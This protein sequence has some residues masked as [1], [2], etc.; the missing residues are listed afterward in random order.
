MTNKRPLSLFDIAWNIWCVASVIGIWPRH[1]EPRLITTTRVPIK[2]PNLHPSLHGLRVVQFS[3]L[4]FHHA[5]SDRFIK[6]LISKIQKLKP[7]VIAFTGDFIC[8]SHLDNP[9]KLQSIFQALKAPFGCYA[10]L[11]NHDYQN[12]VSITSEGHYDVLDSSSINMRRGWRRLFYTPTLSKIVSEKAQKVPMKQELVDMLRATP[13]QLLHNE[14][15]LVP[16]R[17]TFLNICGLGEYVLGRC[18]PKTTFQDYDRSYPG[19]VLAH[20]PDSVPRLQPFPGDLILCG[21]THGGQINIPG[22]WKKFT[23]MENFHLKSGL[24]RIEDKWVYINR[25]VGAVMPFRWFSPPEIT[26]FTLECL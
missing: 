26:L 20:N 1:I 12:Y 4:H 18:D 14:S 23:L 22:M 9:Q 15:L 10:V 6:K 7:D 5:L 21:H 8:A 19:I 16:I 25:G 3:D 11:G 17:N 2:I 24:K 13:F